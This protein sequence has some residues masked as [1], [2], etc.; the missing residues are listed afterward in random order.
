MSKDKR[1]FLIGFSTQVYDILYNS[2]KDKVDN[3]FDEDFK[4]KLKIKVNSRSFQLFEFDT[5]KLDILHNMSELLLK[6]K[7]KIKNIFLDYYEYGATFIYKIN[8]QTE[9]FKILILFM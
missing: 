8:S 1:S 3:D 2:V 6:Y 7:D 5:E 9:I 4:N